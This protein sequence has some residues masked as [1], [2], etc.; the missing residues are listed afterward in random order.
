MLF[1]M[2]TGVILKTVKI[3]DVKLTIPHVY[4]GDPISDG[5]TSAKA[6]YSPCIRG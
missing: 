5:P 1:P 4:R 6:H 3:L 2:Y